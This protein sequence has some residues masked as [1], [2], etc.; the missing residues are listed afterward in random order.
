MF[1]L[2]VLVEFK[3]STYSVIENQMVFNVTLMRQGEPGQDIVV[4]ILPNTSAGTAR[5]M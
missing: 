1:I 4:F 2:G 5:C 3:E